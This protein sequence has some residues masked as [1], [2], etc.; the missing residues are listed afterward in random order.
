M[1]SLG[2]SPT[3]VPFVSLKQKAI[4]AACAYAALLA[5]KEKKTMFKDPLKGDRGAKQFLP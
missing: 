5:D 3:F 2:I 4:W 1:L